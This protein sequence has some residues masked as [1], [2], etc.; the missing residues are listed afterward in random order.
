M[1]VNF[2]LG[3]KVMPVDDRVFSGLDLVVLN[4]IS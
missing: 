3:G 4:V 2:E 1:L